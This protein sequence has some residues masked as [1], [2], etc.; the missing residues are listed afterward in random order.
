MGHSSR[1][2]IS[3]VV[4]I[5]HT[6]QLGNS[7]Q[8]ELFVVPLFLIESTSLCKIFLIKPP[9][10]KSIRIKLDAIAAFQYII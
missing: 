3:P 10:H 8:F 1:N 4:I 5:P 9:V 6:K 7:M 2:S